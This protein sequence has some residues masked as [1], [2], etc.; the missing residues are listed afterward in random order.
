MLSNLNFVNDFRAAVRTLYQL[1]D[2][3]I[4]SSKTSLIIVRPTIPLHFP[5]AREKRQKI[6]SK[7]SPRHFLSFLFNDFSVLRSW[8]FSSSARWIK[9]QFRRNVFSRCTVS[10]ERRDKKSFAD[11]ILTFIWQA[12]IPLEDCLRHCAIRTDSFCNEIRISFIDLGWQK[13]DL[14]PNHIKF[15]K[16]LWKSNKLI[17]CHWWNLIVK[18]NREPQIKFRVRSKNISEDFSI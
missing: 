11:N 18:L 17:S 7:T 6:N 15:L 2:F 9:M 14:N 4:L 10:I 5:I 12:N 16:L 1:I 13:R 8:N 3:I